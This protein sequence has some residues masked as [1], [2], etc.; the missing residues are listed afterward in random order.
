MANNSDIPHDS[1]GAVQH[2]FKTYGGETL[3]RCG[4]DGWIVRFDTLA[5]AKKSITFI[6]MLK[7]WNA[8]LYPDAKNVIRITKV[9][10]GG[11]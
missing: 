8:D 10:D 5:D 3:T 1:V 11:A 6:N 4:P 7:G 2:V 9:G